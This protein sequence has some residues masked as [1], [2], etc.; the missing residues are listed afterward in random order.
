M[1][2]PIAKHLPKLSLADGPLLVF[3]GPYS[4]LAATEALRRIAGERA[5]PPERVICTGDVVAYCAE[6]EETAAAIEDW[7]IHVVQGNCEAQLAGDAE[8]C[9]CGFEDGTECDRLARGWYPFA[10]ARVSQPLKDW[11]GAMPAALA[12]TLS[13][14][15]VRVIHGGVSETA[16]FL[17]ASDPKP[18]KAA[19]LAQAGAELVIAGHCGIPFI[20]RIGPGRV[21]FNPGVIGMPANDGTPDGWY[22]LIE[23]DRAGAVRLSTHRLDYDARAAAAAMRRKGHANEYARSLVTGLWPSMDILPAAERASQGKRLRETALV[24][25]TSETAAP[26]RR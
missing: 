15:R 9:G 17:F 18:V 6:P 11:M 5:I 8:D 4:N 3:G 10:R 19:E 2:L 23:H 16:R 13:G 12:F 7:G 21:W 20:E 25:E 24:I 22:G 14:A 1:A 26:V